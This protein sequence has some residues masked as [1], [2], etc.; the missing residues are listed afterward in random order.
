MRMRPEALLRRGLFNRV[1]E[2][3]TKISPETFGIGLK[4]FDES[5][6]GKLAMKLTINAKP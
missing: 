1:S 6:D 3:R 2:E 4:D 5:L